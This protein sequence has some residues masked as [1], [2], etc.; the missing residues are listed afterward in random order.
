VVEVEGVEVEFSAD[1]LGTIGAQ[2]V[3]GEASASSEDGGFCTNSA[4]VFE[5]GH[6]THIMAAVLDAPVGADGDTGGGGGHRRLAGIKRG[7]GGRVPKAGFGILAPGQARHPGGGDDQAV[8]IR[9]ETAAD[10]EGFDETVLLPAMFVAIDGFGAV[11][12]GPGGAE[13]FDRVVQGLLVVLD[14]GNEDVSGIPGRLK[15]FFD[16]AWRRP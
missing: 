2:D 8:P 4:M 16:S 9:P 13:G 1:V 11:G 7:L 5:E 3:E 10:I 14:L 15:C 6:V 12:R